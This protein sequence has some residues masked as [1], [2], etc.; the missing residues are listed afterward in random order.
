MWYDSFGVGPDPALGVV[1]PG[2]ARD[3]DA[4]RHLE[5]VNR[6]MGDF[7]Q[8]QEPLPIFGGPPEEDNDPT[9]APS[10]PRPTPRTLNLDPSPAVMSPRYYEDAMVD[11]KDDPFFDD[12]STVEWKYNDDLDDATVDENDDGLGDGLDDATVDETDNSFNTTVDEIDDS[13]NT[14]VD[15]IDNSYLPETPP[16]SK[17]QKR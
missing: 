3:A 5:D 4:T 12:D 11:E 16:S 14:T 13:F 10:P 6:Q 8:G 9:L 17:R 7:A 2:A 15:E 1:M